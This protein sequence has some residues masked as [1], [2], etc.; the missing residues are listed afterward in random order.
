VSRAVALPL[1]VALALPL[2]APTPARARGP[3]TSEERKRAVETTRKLESEPL[4]RSAQESRRWLFQWIVEIPD[5]QVTSCKG[6]L[7]ALLED[8]EGAYGELLYLQAV[9]GMA[10]YL[11]EHPKAS[12]W[13]TVQTAG[14]ESTLKAYQSIL[15]ADSESHWDVLDR[16]LAARKAGKLRSLVQKQMSCDAEAGMGPAPRDAI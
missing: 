9:F 10:A 7:D 6:P 13:V 14:M 3:S 8:E 12:D 16:L 11:I 15:R 2:L 5:I 4:A 1:A